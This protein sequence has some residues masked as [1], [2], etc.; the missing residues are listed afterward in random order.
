MSYRKFTLCLVALCLAVTAFAQGGGRETA[1][2][3]INGKKISID[4]GSP[5]WGGQDRL[6]MAST[7][8]VWRLGMNKPTVIETQGDLKVAGKQL[9]A[10]KYSLWA[11]KTGDNSWVLAFHPTV[12]PWGVPELKEGYAA[13]LPL[14]MSTAKDHAE[15]LTISLA[16]MKGKAGIKIH[17]GT[18]VLTGSFDVL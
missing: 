15:K 18:A 2:A 16:D 11:K 4:Y 7:G 5:S 14:T 1:T 12:P 6:A 3:T 8:T 13:E 9:K 10:G 17:W